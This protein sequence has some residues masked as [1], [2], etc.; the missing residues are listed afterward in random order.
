MNSRCTS[1]QAGGAGSSK[2]SEG[3]IAVIGGY[4]VAESTG[5]QYFF[6]LIS[7][8][9]FFFFFFLPVLET[10]KGNFRYIKEHN[11]KK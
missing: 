8:G 2:P 1:Q 6:P 11:G 9:S 5:P 3:F 10:R 7:N 4:S